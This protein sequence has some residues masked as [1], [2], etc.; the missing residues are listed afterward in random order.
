[1]GADGRLA[2]WGAYIGRGDAPVYSITSDYVQVSLVNFVA[3]GLA[4]DGRV[5]CWDIDLNDRLLLLTDPGPWKRIATSGTA[6][7]GVT[8][9][10]DYANNWNK[11]L[12][13]RS[14]RPLM[15]ICGSGLG[16]RNFCTLD[17]DGHIDC[18]GWWESYPSRDRYSTLSCGTMHACGVTTDGRINCWGDCGGGGCDVPVHD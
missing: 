7:A 18:V 4:G 16:L 9:S 11:N 8:V 6:V 3:C 2:C 14:E 12:R 17:I 15:D 5:D 10:G 13:S 1:M